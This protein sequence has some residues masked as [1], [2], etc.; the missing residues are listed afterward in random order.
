MTLLKPSPRYQSRFP[1]HT[2]DAPARGEP[3][4]PTPARAGFLTRIF[5][6]TPAAPPA[7]EPAAPPAPELLA[8]FHDSYDGEGQLQLI[9]RVGAPGRI[10]R[11]TVT[12][13]SH[14]R[15]N[16]KNSPGTAR[17]ELFTRS[18]TWTPLCTVSTREMHDDAYDAYGDHR[19]DP[20]KYAD[21]LLVRAT[22]ALAA[23]LST[24]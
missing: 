19:I 18:E 11:L 14:Y 13:D 17:A 15:A 10:V 3:E 12:Y 21:R 16:K 4:H 1:A 8:T 24:G 5:G 6:P 23:V 22:E 9:Y 2:A 20:H 7:S